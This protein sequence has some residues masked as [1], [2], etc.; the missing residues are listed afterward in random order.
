MPKI[1]FSIVQETYSL[2][3][4]NSVGCDGNKVDVIN[5][6]VKCKST[7]WKKINELDLKI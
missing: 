4:N 2:I 3:N 5:M 7:V 6:R 1:K